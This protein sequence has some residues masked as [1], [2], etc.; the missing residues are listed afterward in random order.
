MTSVH[1]AYECKKIKGENHEKKWT[2]YLLL[3][4][5]IL[6]PTG[7]VFI[8]GSIAET[9]SQQHAIAVLHPTTGNQTTGV[10]NFVKTTD[11]IRITAASDGESSR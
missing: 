9:R 10:V 11:G 3:T 2:I 1:K 6:T 5:L 4:D 8:T 7:I